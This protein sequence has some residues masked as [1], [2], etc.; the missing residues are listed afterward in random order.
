MM[1]FKELAARDIKNVFLNQNEF[2]ERH[3][4]D[5]KL[6]TIIIDGMEVVERSKK[7]VE[8]GRIDGIYEKQI[9]IYVS[10]NEFGPLPA[11]GRRLTFDRSN[12]RVTDAI[13]EGGMYSITLGAVK[14]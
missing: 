1:G 4:V 12:Y 13:D 11:I 5:G 8:Q 14:S 9:L 2:G 7:Q 3:E 10:R 6:M